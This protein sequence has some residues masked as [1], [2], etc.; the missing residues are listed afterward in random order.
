MGPMPSKPAAPRRDD[1][2]SRERIID[3]AIALLDAAGES[4]LTFR[5]LSEHLA[6]GA[7]AIY[8]HVANKADLVTAACDTV[9]ARALQESASGRTPAARLRAVA[10]ALFEAM[11]D[12]PWMGAALARAP[13]ALPGVRILE[14]IGQQVRA[15]GVPPRQQWSTANALL[16][17]IMGVGG[18]NAANA[19]FATAR[20]LDRAAFLGDVAATWTALD[21]GTYPFVRSMAAKLA[22][23]DDRADFLAGIDLIL[24]GIAN[25]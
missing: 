24:G 18:Q 13:A 25:L 21:A 9:I 12:H 15:L 6:T 5:A 3:A 14:H 8:W 7:G 19:Q 10:L 23:H 20:E 4:G 22:T 2:L 11:E 16:S 1:S 17:Y